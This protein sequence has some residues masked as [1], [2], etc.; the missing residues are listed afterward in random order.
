LAEQA[1]FERWPALNYSNNAPRIVVNIPENVSPDRYENALAMLDASAFS[2]DVIGTTPFNISTTHVRYYHVADRGAAEALAGVFDAKARDFTS[3]L[4]SPDKGLLELWVS[5]EGVRKV[6]VVTRP[7]ARPDVVARSDSTTVAPRKANLL[8]RIYVAFGGLADRSERG[9]TRDRSPSG[10]AALSGAGAGS[11]SESAA[12]G[13][14]SSVSSSGGGGMT[15]SGGSSSSGGRATGSG[16]SSSSSGSG[17]SGSS[18]GSGD[19]AESDA[20]DGTSAGGSTGGKGG[21]KGGGK[22]GKKG[23]GKGGSNGKGKGGKKD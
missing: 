21:N 9:A 10:S 11:G 16:S 22:G 13:S 5:G 14:A 20:G 3:Y 12:G 7:T 19:G 1:N 2:A 6:P 17:A 23:G 18:S 4:P 15:E 8:E